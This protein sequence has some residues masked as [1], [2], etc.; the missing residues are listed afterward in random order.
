MYN[1]TI[2]YRLYV[3]CNISAWYVTNSVGGLEKR[4]NYSDVLILP[5]GFI[6]VCDINV[7]SRA[8]RLINLEI[9]VLVRS[10]KSS[11]DGLG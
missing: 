11:N 8:Q 6:N 3:C 7:V 2:L 10:L 1:Y 4:V 9:P 5:L